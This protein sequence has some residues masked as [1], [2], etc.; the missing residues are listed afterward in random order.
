VLSPETL[1][2]YRRMTPSERL[3][4]TLE[5]IREETPYLLRGTAEQVERQFKLLRR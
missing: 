1:E 4:V 2:Y 5:L 3:R